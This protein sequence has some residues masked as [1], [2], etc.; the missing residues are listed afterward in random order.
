MSNNDQ[1]RNEVWGL[2]QLFQAPI[3]KIIQALAS[4]MLPL[5]GRWRRE[6][7]EKRKAELR[8]TK[9]GTATTPKPEFSNPFRCCIFFGFF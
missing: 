2:L 8:D 5:P 3:D 9:G 7:R 4:W 6:K 1:E